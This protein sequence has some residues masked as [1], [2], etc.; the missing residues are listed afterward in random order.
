MWTWAS[1]MNVPAPRNA[2]VSM[3]PLD[4]SSIVSGWVGGGAGPEQGLVEPRDD[5][6]GAVR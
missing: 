2:S 5:A 3:I 4:S 6:E 1:K